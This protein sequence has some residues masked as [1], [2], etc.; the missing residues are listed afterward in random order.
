MR[1]SLLPG[2]LAA[3]KRNVD[4]GASSLRLFE[5]GRRYFAPSD[6]SSDERPT[7]GMVLAGEKTPRGW[8]TGKAAGVRCVRRQG[9]GAGAARRGWRAGGQS[10]GDGRG[11]AAVP[12]RP[13]GDAAAWPQDRA[14]PLRHAA[15]GDLAPVRYRRCR[16]WR[17]RFSSM[18]S[19]RA[20]RARASRAQPM[21]RPRCRAVTR[22]FAFLV[23]ADLPAGDLVRAVR[24]ADKASIV[25]AR[26]FDMFAGAG[27]PEG[28]KSL[29]VEV[30]LQPERKELSPTAELKA[31]SMRSLVLWTKLGG[32][33]SPLT[34]SC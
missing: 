26:L 34:S 16:S 7:L 32:S 4:R 19:R 15:S 13:V 33:A 31:I 6:G 14:G 8:A 18:R 17:W 1:P 12:S 29:A 30:T 3:A 23:P 2:L 22:D 5:I 20:R 24:G 28:Q 27:V 21:P 9:R 25:D 11:R 10:A